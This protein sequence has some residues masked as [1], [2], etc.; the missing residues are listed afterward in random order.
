MN[1]VFKKVYIVSDSILSDFNQ[2]ITIL[3]FHAIDHSYNWRIHVED[4]SGTA[5][6]LTE[7]EAQSWAAMR[8]CRFSA[9]R[10][11]H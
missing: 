8:L 4:R 11:L 2:L 3:T 1:N 10:T 7:N 5:S 6:H 9:D